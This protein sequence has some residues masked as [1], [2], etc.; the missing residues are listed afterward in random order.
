MKKIEEILNGIEIV[1][2]IGTK[3]RVISGIEFDSRKVGKDSLFVAVKGYKSDG[4]DFI[5][6]AIASGAS[7][8]ICEI[9]PEKPDKSICWIKTGDSAKALG[10]AASNFFGN[11][12]YSLNLVGVTGTNG[13]TTIALCY[14]GCSCGWV[15]NAD[16][17]QLFAIILMKRNLR[18]HI[19]HPILF[20]ST[21]FYQRWSARDVI[22]HLWKSALT[23][24]I[25]NG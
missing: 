20:S 9:L 7:A 4:H 24:L 5:N 11:P 3:N 14:T 19:Q 17:F 2:V 21:D 18:R 16:C 25:R 22:M 13:K 15:I 1:S 10:L 12:S 8:V 23:L 6:S